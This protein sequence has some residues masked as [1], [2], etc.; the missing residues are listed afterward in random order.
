MIIYIYNI[1]YYIYILYPHLQWRFIDLQI[2]ASL[3][4]M[5]ENTIIQNTIFIIIFIYNY[6][7]IQFLHSSIFIFYFFFQQ[8]LLFILLIYLI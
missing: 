5:Y 1:L 3:F 7:T 6:Y 4:V 8:S 2:F